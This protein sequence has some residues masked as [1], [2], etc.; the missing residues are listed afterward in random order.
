MYELVIKEG[1]NYIRTNEH[2]LDVVLVHHGKPVVA[3]ILLLRRIYG[4]QS[5]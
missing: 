5:W 4:S 1:I 3:C 2:R